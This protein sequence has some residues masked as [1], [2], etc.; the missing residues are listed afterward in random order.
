M[1]HKTVLAVD[2]G[3]ESGRVTAVH[4]D[5]E[6]LT[7]EELHRF[8]NGAVNARG[9]LYWDFLRL[10]AEIQ[11]GIERGKAHQPAGIGVDTWGVD[12]GLLDRDGRLLSNPVCYRDDRTEGMM[13]AAFA[14]VPQAEIYAQTGIQFARYNT[15][16]QLLSLVQS[17]S[18]L[19]DVADT[20]LL[21]PDLLNYWLTGVQAAEQT[22]ASTTQMLDVQT[23]QWATGLLARLDIP[24]HMLPPIVA[25]GTRLGSYQ[26]I[27][28]FASGGHDTASAVAAVPTT[29]ADYGY[30]SSGTW[31][32][33][34]LEMERPFVT[35]AAFAANVTN[36]GGV[37]GS[38]R[39]LANVAGLW[40][41]QQCRAAWRGHGREFDYPTLVKLAEAARPHT[42]FI[43]PNAPEFLTPGDYP[44]LVAAFCARSGQP[45]PPD[46]GAVVR[47][48]LES[49]ALEYRTLF[50]RL[51]H[52][53]GRAL[54]VIH[55]VGGGTQNQLLNQ[56]TADATGRTVITGP[57]E[58]TVLGN[59]LVQ[60]I[61]LGE[62]ADLRQGRQVVAQSGLLRRYEPG[63]E[64][65]VWDEAHRRYQAL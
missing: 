22:I 63:G 18:P 2:L 48:L 41:L 30:I 46:E 44:A 25:S 21:S 17:Q 4:F 53:T 60:L 52:L 15:L 34:G 3:A 26:N 62:L 64:T 27:P 6:R 50:A 49:L 5:G 55:I 8:P 9:T 40:L 28:V 57:I 24:T 11:A 37:D 38:V 45:A 20:L 56:M 7:I 32:L 51:A 36:E 29:T 14:R 61:A 54:E 13:A 16:Y 59:A 35:P 47:V 31:S 58:A 10:W 23:R 65:A 42:A 1:T 12:F 19:L 33:V 39:L 43:N